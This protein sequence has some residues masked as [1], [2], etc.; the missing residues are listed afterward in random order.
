MRVLIT[1]KAERDLDKLDNNIRKRLVKASHGHYI[2]T[3]SRRLPA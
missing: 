3:V 2:D 1:G